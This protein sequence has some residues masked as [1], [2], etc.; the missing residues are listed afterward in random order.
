MIIID[1]LVPYFEVSGNRALRRWA[2][3]SQ[4]NHFINSIKSI[5][6][7]SISVCQ[8]IIQM[9][10]IHSAAEQDGPSMQNVEGNRLSVKVPN[11]NQR[12]TQIP[13]AIPVTGRGGL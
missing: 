12:L 4:P 7:V 6:L 3:N 5:L 8:L 2:M 13:K 10:F 9:H 11:D 1:D